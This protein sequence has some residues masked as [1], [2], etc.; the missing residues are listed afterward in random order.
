[1][2]SIGLSIG[3]VLILFIIG[4]FLF[5]FKIPIINMVIICS[6]LFV[7]DSITVF[8]DYK[9]QTNCEEVWSG[10][11]IDVEHNEEW[12]EWIPERGHYDDDGKYHVDEE[13]HWEH[14]NASNYITTS[15][16]GRK[17]VSSTLDGKKFTDRFVNNTKELK[18]YYPIGMPTA[19]I[20]IYENKVQASD[21]IFNYKDINIDNY[22]DKLP[23]YPKQVYKYCINRFVGEIPNK[24]NIV[25]KINEWNR[26]LN[27]TNNPNNTEKKKSYKQVNLIFVNLGDISQE[28]GKALQMYWNNGN[29]NDYI[30]AFGSK[31]NKITWV[32]SFSWCENEDLKIETNN[33]LKAEPNDTTKFINKVD[34]VG[35]AIEEKFTRKEFADF[36]YINIE[37]SRIAN[38]FII[39][40]TIL[41]L[42]LV[43]LIKD[44]EE[45]I[46]G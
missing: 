42:I 8:I 34:L 10:Q 1:M 5:N 17:Y 12:D 9:S 30:I 4:K 20:H 44:E 39:F 24:Q 19:S 31:N 37:V 21:S 26:D 40:F 7:F 33:I 2:F 6:V 46:F 29:K 35:K 43:C 25:N 27:N 16:D 38:R 28:Y 14:H 18:Q 3:I 13:A 23:E 41:A 22:K 15:D 45:C 36:S 32:H 11:I